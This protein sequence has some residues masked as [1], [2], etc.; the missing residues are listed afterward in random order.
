MVWKNSEIFS[1]KF[2]PGLDIR[3]NLREVTI[4]LPDPV[5]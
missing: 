2:Q 5:Y 1:Q 3:D 4:L